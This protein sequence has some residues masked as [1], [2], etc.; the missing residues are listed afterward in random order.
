VQTFTLA[1]K[2]EDRAARADSLPV[3]G[4][5]APFQHQAAYIIVRL[6]KRDPAHQKSYEEAGP[7]V[8]SAFQ[9]YEAKRLE[10]EWMTS[11]RS[12]HPVVENRPELKKAFAV[13]E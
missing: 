6:D 10:S 11:V 12:R 13:V 8:S 7:E 3:L 4:Y 9:D 1:P 5:S 2:A